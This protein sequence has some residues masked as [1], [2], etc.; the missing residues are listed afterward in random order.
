MQERFYAS[1]SCVQKNCA[2]LGVHPSYLPPTWVRK[3][4]YAAV[5]GNPCDPVQIDEKF[6]LEERPAK[7]SVNFFRG[8][9]G[10]LRI[11]LLSFQ[12]L[13]RPGCAAQLLC[14]HTA[15]GFAPHRLH[16]D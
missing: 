12:Y 4:T 14:F 10:A 11:P 16:Q 5:S 6:K 8:I 13:R 15:G 1:G 9:K 2:I 3:R 7:F